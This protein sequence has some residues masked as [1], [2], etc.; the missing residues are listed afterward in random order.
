M[1]NYPEFIAPS[2]RPWS[3]LKASKK[4]LFVR[5]AKR[6]YFKYNGGNMSYFW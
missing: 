4:A 1:E 5:H 2:Y 6:E 3:K